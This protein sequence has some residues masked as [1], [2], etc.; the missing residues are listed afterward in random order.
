MNEG[1]Y[2]KFPRAVSDFKLIWKEER[3]FGTE[4]KHNTSRK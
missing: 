3:K 4:K 1:V 2:G